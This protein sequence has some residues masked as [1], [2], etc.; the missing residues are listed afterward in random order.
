MS[1]QAGLTVALDAKTQAQPIPRLSIDV[2][3][4]PFW[5]VI[6]QIAQKTGI[7]PA[8][9][10]LVAAHDNSRNRITLSGGSDFATLP[11]QMSRNFYVTA[12]CSV[13]R[14]PQ[15]QILLSI[16]A[17]PKLSLVPERRQKIGEIQD[18]TGKSLRRFFSSDKSGSD[19]SDRF[20]LLRLGL[21]DAP[22]PGAKI[23]GLQGSV[24]VQ[25]AIKRDVWEISDVLHA[26]NASHRMPYGTWAMPQ[27]ERVSD[28]VYHVNFTLE[29]ERGQAQPPGLSGDYDNFLEGMRLLD[30]NGRS[31]R[32]ADSNYASG[33]IGGQAPPRRIFRCTFRRDRA[34]DPRLG[35]PA[36]LV[37]ELPLDTQ[38]IEVPVDL[39]DLPILAPPAPGAGQQ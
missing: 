2:D 35:E 10:P 36:K 7:G 3:V 31:W 5:L 15:S 14:V 11:G 39:K 18:A 20:R 23:A 30:A 22:N 4:E 12:A 33:L 1:A 28:D 9:P 32:A 34:A 21:R 16:Y 25:A 29:Y 13:Q 26:H 19:G 8:S 37:W 38:E 17:D 27:L 6:R 24:W